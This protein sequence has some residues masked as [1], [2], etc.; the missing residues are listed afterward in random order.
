MGALFLDG[1]YVVNP[2]EFSISSIANGFAIR[3]ILRNLA[4]FFVVYN[5]ILSYDVREPINGHLY[6]F[7][8]LSEN[9]SDNNII[10]IL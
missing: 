10:I 2:S 1:L 3:N 4:V 8:I 6:S 7:F 5:F 9:N